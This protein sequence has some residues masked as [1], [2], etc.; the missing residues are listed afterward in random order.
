VERE[1]T[2]LDIESQHAHRDNE[3]LNNTWYSYMI[4]SLIETHNVPFNPSV[5]QTGRNIPVLDSD[6]FVFIRVA[7]DAAKRN[8][9]MRLCRSLMIYGALSHRLEA[10]MRMSATAL[11]IKAVFRYIGPGCMK[12]LFENEEAT[13]CTE[14][15]INF[16]KLSDTNDVH[17]D[18]LHDRLGVK[19]AFRRLNRIAERDEEVGDWSLVIFSSVACAATTIW[20]FGGGWRDVL[21]S[22][23]ISFIVSYLQN[24]IA[25]MGVMYITEF[26]GVLISSFLAR[27]F[28]SIV[29]KNK[30]PL[31]FAALAYSSI[32]NLLPGG[33]ILRA[34]LELQSGNMLA[35]GVR[36]IHAIFYSF[37]LS[38]GVTLGAILYGAMDRNAVSSSDC[39]D[40]VP[41]QW[42]TLAV[43]VWFF[44]LSMLNQPKWKQMPLMLTTALIGWFSSLRFE[45]V[46]TPAIG[47]FLIG[48]IG[49]LQS[50]FGVKIKNKALDA[51]QGCLQS[52]MMGFGKRTRGRSK[53]GYMYD[54]DGC[55]DTDIAVTPRSRR[56]V[57]SLPTVA[58]LPAISLHG[59]GGIADLQLLDIVIEAAHK[60]NTFGVDMNEVMG[61]DIV[62]FTSRVI[63]LVVWVG[64]SMTVGLFAS[65]LL[66]YPFG[67]KH[68]GVFV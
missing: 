11:G 1:D 48:L 14:E 26:F 67:R 46:G 2:Y 9:L 62:E 40:T 37:V 32:S 43:L 6:A 4:M 21:V 30:H 7:D 54:S 65:T 23:A 15:G 63:R 45:S 51:W 22:F 19:A 25:P 17:Q 59:P 31:C 57:Y 44:C 24:M 36:M 68:S 66:V 33:L 34:S 10:T 12:C 47:A 56:A 50:R 27:A 13:I 53:A 49:N 20:A 60:A 18:V 5:E 55:S 64:I 39:Y 61:G 42:Q 35:G 58:L 28:G 16:S 29:H 41:E 3:E 8:Y 52:N 38:L